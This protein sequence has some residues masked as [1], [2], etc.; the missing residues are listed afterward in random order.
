MFKPFHFSIVKPSLIVLREYV[1]RWSN[2]I[3]LAMSSF[4]LENIPPQV[5]L[6]SQMPSPRKMIDLLI[7]INAL[8]LGSFNEAC[9]KHVP[10]ISANKPKSC[11]LQ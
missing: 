11:C 8:Q 2:I 10:S 3:L 9:P 1:C 7:L 4:H 6:S 5:V